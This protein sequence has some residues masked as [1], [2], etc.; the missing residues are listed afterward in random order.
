[1]LGLFSI[2]LGVVIVGCCLF[3]FMRVRF[4]VVSVLR[5]GGIEYG[6]W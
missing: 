4:C 6:F 5:S 1:V 2:R 3:M